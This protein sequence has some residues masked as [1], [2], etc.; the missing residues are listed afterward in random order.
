MKKI[1]LCFMLTFLSFPAW[2]E[3][4]VIFL[5]HRSADE[6]LPIILPLL[7]KGDRASGMGNQLI[8]RTSSANLAAIKRLLPD[9]DTVPRRLRITVMQDVDS[10]TVRRLTEMSGS[11]GLGHDARITAPDSAGNGGF[12][13]EAGQGADRMRARIISTRS[14]EDDKKT[15]QV[16]VVEGGRAL[17]SAGKVLAV[18]QHPQGVRRW[19]PDS[20]AVT[21]PQHQVVQSPWGAQVIDGTQYRDLSSGFYVRPRISG[22]RVTLEISVQ[23]ATLAPG[24]PS[25]TPSFTL[26]VTREQQVS[27]TV[28]GRLGEWMELGGIS[29]QT[30]DDGST[31]SARSM[32]DTDERRNIL[33]KVEEMP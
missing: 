32:S 25:F 22:E 8:L 9:I 29:R 5:Q 7:D 33:L 14:L 31:L 30:A 6:V 11:V 15:Q 20:S 10:E 1:I 26:P 12:T 19:V 28:S 17:I 23:D 13:A 18:P 21:L 24:D 16:Q 2:A 27:T 3:L 4:E